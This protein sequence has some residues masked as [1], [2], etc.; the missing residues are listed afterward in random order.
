MSS[1]PCL[2]DTVCRLLPIVWHGDKTKDVTRIH[3]YHA[4]LQCLDEFVP[5]A[6][7]VTTIN[8]E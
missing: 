8:Y 4:Y 3:S 2:T 7:L 1:C 6:L 5:D